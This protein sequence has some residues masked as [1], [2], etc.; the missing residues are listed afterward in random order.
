M[1][2]CTMTSLDLPNKKIKQKTRKMSDNTQKKKYLASIQIE[3]DVSEE[4]EEQEEEEEEE[5]DHIETDDEEMDMDEDDDD[6]EDEDV[7]TPKKNKRKGKENN[8][9]K[10]QYMTFTAAKNILRHLIKK[11]AGDPEVFFGEKG[12]NFRFSNGL[13]VKTHSAIEDLFLKFGNVACNLPSQEG[14]FTLSGDHILTT[15]CMK[16][17]IDNIFKNT[18]KTQCCELTE[19][20]YMSFKKKKAGKI[21]VK[22][23]LIGAGIIV[24]KEKK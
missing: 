22:D 18:K 15:F 8:N 11:H 5:E 24:G 19:T 7:E 10:H 4:E 17:N 12:A 21:C 20:E 3:E 9:A 14:K 1:C 6:D 2:Q 13:M 16:K 23:A